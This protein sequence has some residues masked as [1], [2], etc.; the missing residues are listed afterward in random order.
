M[1]AIVMVAVVAVAAMAPASASADSLAFIRDSNVWLANADGTGQ[2]QVTFD[3]TASAPY[4]SPSQSD[5]GTVVAIRAATGQRRQIYRMSQSG[6]L[7]NPPINTPAPGTGAIDDKVSPDGALVAY[8]FVTTVSDPICPFCVS[9][10][11]RVLLSH[12]DRFT[13]A[14]EVGT[15]NTGGWPSWVSNDTIT[16]GSGSPTQWYYRLGMPEAAEWFADSDVEPN[17]FL[18]L[19]DA[20]A[21]PT[22][23]RLA[24][25]RGDNQET[26]LLLRM[27]APPPTKPTIANATCDGFAGPNGKFVDPTW[28]SDGRLLAWQENDGVWVAAIPADLADCAGFGAPALRIPGAT[29]PDFSP[30]A[31][32]PGPR[33]PCGNPGN[34]AMC[35]LPLPA[36]IVTL[37][38]QLTTL[39]SAQAKALRKLGIRGLRR[40]GQFKVTFQAPGAG[41]LVVK[42]TTTAKR[43]TLLASGRL[44]FTKAAKRTVAVKLTRKGKSALRHARRLR[45]RLQISFTPKGAKATTVKIAVAL[46]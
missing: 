21:A 17:T 45:T 7:L 11:N 18:T 19:L 4:E 46:K 30:A 39:L 28:S 29:H 14:D 16:L 22:G 41:T 32:N 20:E 9:A 35:A 13:N 10:A 2:Y 8:W 5:G 25:V 1:K 3:G 38:Q 24:V 26:L 33:P 6:A 27:T 37:R 42:L 23:D 31:I 15:P 36:P 34:P 12:S 44:V 43:P 40:K